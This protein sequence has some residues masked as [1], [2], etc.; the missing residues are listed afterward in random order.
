M[1]S[2]LTILMIAVFASVAVLGFIGIGHMDEMAHHGCLAAL[3]QNGDC[4]IASGTPLASAFFHLDILRSFSLALLANAVLLLALAAA[5]LFG[6][7]NQLIPQDT[8]RIRELFLYTKRLSLINNDFLTS[9][10]S[11]LSLHLN[12]PAYSASA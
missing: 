7:K 11:W 10:L 1:K 12:S 4:P 2:A 6:L 5:V 3:A 8:L 9:N